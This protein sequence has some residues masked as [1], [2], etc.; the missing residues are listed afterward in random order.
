[1]IRFIQS[2]SATASTHCLYS[3]IAFDPINYTIVTVIKKKGGNVLVSL[4]RGKKKKLRLVFDFQIL[5][6]IRNFY[7]EASGAFLLGESRLVGQSK[8]IYI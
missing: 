8:V 5:L 6:K 4:I 2:Q 7:E 3:C 1:M